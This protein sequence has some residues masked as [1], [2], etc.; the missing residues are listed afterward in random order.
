MQCYFEDY[1]RERWGMSR[2]YA[3][4]VIDAAQVAVAMSAIADTAP[5]NEGQARELVPLHKQDPEAAARV[6]QE[7][8]ATERKVTAPALAGAFGFWVTRRKRS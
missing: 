8:V 3:Y 2:A 5:A 4:N 6:W 1:C 7:T